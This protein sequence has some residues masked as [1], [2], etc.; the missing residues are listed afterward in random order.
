MISAF[1]TGFLGSFHCVG[2]CG[3]LALAAQARHWQSAVLYHL[4][5][6]LT[7][8]V[9]GAMFGLLG[10][11]LYIGGF[12]QYTSI[13]IGVLMI[14]F[15]LMPYQNFP[16]LFKLYQRFKQHINPLKLKNKWLSG[17]LL[18]ILNGLL[19][20]GLVYVAIFASIATSDMWYGA[21]YMFLF[22]MGT[23]PML[24]LLGVAPKLLPLSWRSQLVKAVPVFVVCVG[25]LLIVRG[26][27]LNIPYISPYLQRYVEITVCH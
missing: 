14:V 10:R 27:N 9:L 26:L 12:Q 13:L 18:G 4:G 8:A 1:I 22:G 11:G 7:Y 16:L 25:L 19:P 24:V 2:M 23:I 5:R 17:F 20:C 21:G 15:V 6:S 3:G